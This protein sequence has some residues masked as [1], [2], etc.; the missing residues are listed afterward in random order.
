MIDPEELPALPWYWLTVEQLATVAGVSIR[1][2]REA[3]KRC[4]EG[5]SWRGIAL[6][7][8][9]V[10][11]K[12][13]QI[14]AASL[15]ADLR[16]TWLATSPAPVLPPEPK[17]ERNQAP[18]LVQDLQSWHDKLPHAEWIE[19]AKRIEALILP[20]LA[21]LK[22]S[23]KRGSV[24]KDIVYR[25]QVGADGKIK[26]LTLRTVA[27]W[28]EK[29]EAGGL[30]AL[31]RRRRHEERP[32][33]ILGRIWDDACP[34]PLDQ[35]T[36]IA[37]DIKT[38]IK[39]L[40]ATANPG[41]K[42]TEILAAGRLVELC[43]EAGWEGATQELC[44]LGRH[45]VER[46]KEFAIVHTAEKDAKR[47]SDL[48]KPRIIRDHSLCKPM[49][50]VVGDVHPVDVLVTRD[51]GSIATPRLIAWYDFATHRLFATLILLDKGKGVTQ[52]DVWASFAAMVEAWGLP[53]R[54]YLDNG[55]E[56]GWEPLIR[57]FN[58]LSSL[59]IGLREFNAAIAE[60]SPHPE[61]APEQ[62]IRH[63]GAIVR[64]LPY[65]ASA[66]PIEGSF[67]ALEKVLSM[68]PGYIGGDRMNKRAPKLG[69]QHAAWG[70][71]SAFENAFIHALTFW[72]SLPQQGNLDNRSPNAAFD[73]CCADGWQAVRIPR[74]ALVYALSE[75]VSCKVHSNGIMVDGDRYD[76]DELVSLRQQ[77]VTVRY[78][79]WAPERLVFL[80]NAPDLAGAAWIDRAP[81]FHALDADGA[82]EQSRKQGIQRRH[83]SSLKAQTDTLD[84]PA[85]LER[86]NASQPPANE[87]PFGP[88]ISLGPQVAA[89]V[90]AGERK[91]P[92]KQEIRRLRQ[93]ETHD[94]VTG[95]VRSLA[96]N[97]PLPT[98]RPAPPPTPFNLAD[99]LPMP[100]AR[101][102]RPT[103][104]DPFALPALAAGQS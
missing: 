26:P 58:E 72:H 68:L 100:D 40:W 14:S 63:A 19:E 2:A 92:K 102:A 49:E 47:F 23:R 36:G 11:G 95:T 9:K 6:D 70:D 59:V 3:C 82:A 65:N 80:P 67:S 75:T 101:P 52:A 24:I 21:Y 81:I 15:P 45:A 79:K 69:K 43:R 57:G 103:D 78:A 53:E 10:A 91:P 25:G 35:K 90:E 76:G 44:M 1:N 18:A 104:A 96:D 5:G 33:V 8:R 48:Y 64:A 84:M 56:Y 32:R 13:Y 20:A 94:P 98:A 89:L 27:N 28:I 93:N 22:R 4:H 54:L 83:I 55:S 74:E 30:A 88:T 37:E 86:H 38:Y 60:T 34:L 73:D 61:N 62:P 41:W 42:K 71:A 99:L 77:R 66:K 29:Y 31:V 51:D 97:L 7:V 39:S 16:S 17:P 12:T 50:I 46:F 85:E 87:T